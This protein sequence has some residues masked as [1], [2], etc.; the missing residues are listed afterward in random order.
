MRA[1]PDEVIIR[2]VGRHVHGESVLHVPDEV[3]IAVVEVEND[4]IERFHGYCL[5]VSASLPSAVELG[6][7]TTSEERC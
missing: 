1:D 2:R 7:V 5:C 4:G 6:L 3:A